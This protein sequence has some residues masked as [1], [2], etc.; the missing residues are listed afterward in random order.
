[1]LK[2][3]L[4]YLAPLFTLESVGRTLSKNSFPK[5]EQLLATVKMTDSLDDTK[6]VGLC[7]AMALCKEEAFDALPGLLKHLPEVR[8]NKVRLE[9]QHYLGNI[10]PSTLVTK[11]L[12]ENYDILERSLI[13]VIKHAN[14]TLD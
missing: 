1:M 10:H 5:F 12:H 3:R 2:R 8:L 11:W 6:L 4:I 13:P 7:F 9:L 14:E